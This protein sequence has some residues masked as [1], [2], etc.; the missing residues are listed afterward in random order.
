MEDITFESFGISSEVLEGIQNL[1]WIS[2]LQIQIQTV[3]KILSGGDMIIQARTGT[4][5]T[6]AFGIPIVQIIDPH[7]NVIQALVLT[8]TREL[9]IQVS[10]ELQKLGQPRNVKCLTVYGGDPIKRQLAGLRQG[11]HVIAGTPGRVLDHLR[12]QSMDFSNLKIFVLDEADEMLSMGFYREMTQILAYIPEERQTVLCSATIPPTVENLA[13][14]YLR[15]PD[16]VSLIEKDRIVP[17]IDHRWC[18]VKT[19]DKPRT[20]LALLRQE[21]PESCIIFCNTRDDVRKVAGYLQLNGVAVEMISGELTQRMRERVMSGIKSGEM[22]YMVATDIAARGIDIEGLSHVF[23][24]G[25]PETPEVYIHRTGRTGRVG[26]SGN[27]ISLVGGLDI[28]H[29][30]L[31]EKIRGLQIKKLE[32]PKPETVEARWTAEALEGLAQLVP[33][34]K[35]KPLRPVLFDRLMGQEPK[36]KVLAEKILENDGAASIIAALLEHTA[37][38]EEKI[39]FKRQAPPPPAEP[40]AKGRDKS[41]PGRSGR[42]KPG[43]RGPHNRPSRPR[44]K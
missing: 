27:A 22:R 11:V 35:D 40:Q 3:P 1:G 26:R 17:E 20:M 19:M 2:P 9:A 42:K 16:R 13:A 6:G 24:Y 5:K 38:L 15:S 8:P 43:S 33:E 14:T 4:G 23:N 31:I 18:M 7:K 29:W 28:V 34:D 41:R 32:L 44:S 10:G 37:R 36:F 39:F 21:R 30:G 12:H 25:V